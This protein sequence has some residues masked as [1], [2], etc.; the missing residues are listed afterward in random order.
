VK[1]ERRE[2]STAASVVLRMLAA[3]G[4]LAG[5]S[6]A[7]RY[8]EAGALA[9]NG[10][11]SVSST[12]LGGSQSQPAGSPTAGSSVEPGAGAK[13]GKDYCAR[14]S[15]GDTSKCPKLYKKAKHGKGYAG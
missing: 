11:Q 8:I 1:G 13:H 4:A 9:G 2:V 15:D 3:A 10:V 7:M 12:G 5:G 6:S 14:G